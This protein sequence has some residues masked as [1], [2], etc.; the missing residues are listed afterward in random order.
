[1]ALVLT[2]VV[3]YPKQGF[4]QL[5]YH[6]QWFGFADNRE[7]TTEYPQYLAKGQGLSQT[8][9][10]MN[11]MPYAEYAIDSNSTFGAGFNLIY[12]FGD[13]YKLT[14]QLV[15]YYN[16]KNRRVSF[17]MGSFNRQGLMNYPL[18]LLSDSVYY[19]R[20]NIE[21][22]FLQF[23]SQ[24]NY[25]NI[26]VDW[27][28][29][30]TDTT[31]EA[32]LTGTSGRLSFGNVFVDNFV[33]LHHFSHTTVHDTSLHLRENGGAYLR[34][35][36]NFK[37]L[38]HVDSCTFSVGYMQ[39]FDRLRNV[40]PWQTP[41]GLMLEG[42]IQYKRFGLEAVYFTGEGL[43]TSFNDGNY[44]VITP[45]GHYGRVNL[46]AIPFKSARIESRFAWGI[47]FFEDKIG[48]SQQLWVFIKI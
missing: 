8:F 35:G 1:M 29:H 13:N 15:A 12:N 25:Q 36:Y 37:T 17:T 11:L 43:R 26:W 14:P 21:G 42:A 48:N 9:F 24:T 46:L 30:G 41:G 18:A 20:P 4:G 6:A 27:T 19:V 16:Y 39:Y 31:R 28:G 38:A 10:G 7:Y 3:C 22:L 33:I 40:Y 45:N 23:G 44:D 5:T 47:H 32:F 2:L 34:L